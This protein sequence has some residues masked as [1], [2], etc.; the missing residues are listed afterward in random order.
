MR[1]RS[2]DDLSW[3]LD[4][5]G[6]PD[7]EKSG[8]EITGRI[9]VPDPNPV[10]LELMLLVFAA[11]RCLHLLVTVDFPASIRQ[12]AFVIQKSIESRPARDGVI[13]LNYLGFSLKQQDSN[14]QFLNKL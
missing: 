8:R 9:M 13:M 3:K 7:V 4:R 1:I 6:W 11:A 14:Q 10:F 2:H 12:Q 5:P